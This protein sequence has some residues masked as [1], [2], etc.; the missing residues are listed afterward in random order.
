VSITSIPIVDVEP[1]VRSLDDPASGRAVGE[2]GAAC[3]EHGFFY[4]VGHGVDEELQ[5]RLEETS[6]AF[7]ELA[8]ERKLEIRMERGGRAWRG[9][10]PVGA[11]LTSGRPDQKEGVY[12]GR[13]LGPDDPRVRAGLPL[14]GAN[15]FPEDVPELRPAVLDYL[16]A[17]EDLGHALMRGIALSLGRPADF[18]A[19]LL[20][21]DPLVLFRAFHYPALAPALDPAPLGSVQGEDAEEGE[22]SV[23]EHTDYGLLTILRQDDCGGLQVK[24][25]GRFRD[26]PP[27][28]GSFVC[29]IGDM[30]DRMSSGRYRSTPH[31]VRNPTSRGRLSF[32]FFFDPAFEARV[33]P[34][35]PSLEI[36]DDARE[37]WD[38]TSVHAFDG[39]YG[40][41]LIGKVSKV[42]PELGREQLPAQPRSA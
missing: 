25:G 35:D 27:I 26:A 9:Y 36:S 14:H 31:R 28:A 20:T 15:L 8:P 24:T 23:G 21:R 39:T 34:I 12:F 42:F 30:L 41:Y 3:R 6:R 11:E 1:L 29:N 18:F 4:V 16:S 2:I 33:A 10:F 7:F 19:E 38:G 37:R 32:P 17:M 40:D 13:E 22:W 5:T